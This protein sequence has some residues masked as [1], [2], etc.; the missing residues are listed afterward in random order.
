MNA[1]IW[2]TRFET[3]IPSVDQQHRHLVD[4]TN[5]L[6]DHLLRGNLDQTQLQDLFHE[7]ANYSRYHFD[8]EE[9]LMR[10]AQIDEQ[11]LQTHI[12][13]HHQFT[14]QVVSLWRSRETL[15]HPGETL[16]SF[17]CAWLTA[18]ILGEDHAMARQMS[19][20]SQGISPELAREQEA[21]QKDPVTDILLDA[22]GRLYAV[23]VEQNHSLSNTNELLEQKVQER[24]LALTQA[25]DELE[26]EQV[27]L[28]NLLAK[29]E[30]AQQQLLQSEKMAA[31][32]QLAAGV[33]HEI[34]NPIG[35]I[36]SNFSTLRRYTDGL[37]NVLKAYK[38]GNAKEI[39]V[40]C[41]VADL[42]FLKADLPTLLNES[43]EGLSRVTKIVQEL[44]NFSHVDDSGIQDTDL[45][46]GIET[47][48]KVAWHEIKPKADIVWKLEKLPLVP[49][50]AGDINQVFMSIILNA[51]QAMDQRGT[52]TLR[53]GVA[54]HYA[55]IEVEDTG[56]G[57]TDEVRKRLFEPFFTTKKLGE[58]IGLGL[59]IAYD[60]V[61][62]KHQGYI[63][64]SSTPGKGTTVRVGLPIA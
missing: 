55:W 38:T 56:R 47:T 21:A 7:L 44:K 33:A 32:G 50:V 3:G 43:E 40:A 49:C 1:F 19:A 51:A 63:D 60:I 9:N 53:S 57:M 2:D 22:M 28:T 45:N 6:S 8:N 25:K 24:T 64:V 42:D 34:N 31:V 29:V 12:A 18:H 41:Q 11:H 10:E 13:H 15:E 48:V 27:E 61:V 62:H 23:L 52:I 30:A 36:N 26:R 20:I 5:V 14:Q 58:G 37:L 17:L 4:L 35:F 16:H 54:H 46:T 59:S 39:E